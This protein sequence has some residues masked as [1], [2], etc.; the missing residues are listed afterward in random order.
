MKK[1]VVCQWIESESGNYYTPVCY[2]TPNHQFLVAQLD[3]L[4]GNGKHYIILDSE[5]RIPET[6]QDV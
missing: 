4:K 1:Y 3:K 6:K 2:P 5:Q